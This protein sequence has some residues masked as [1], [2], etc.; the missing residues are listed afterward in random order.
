MPKNARPLD[1]IMIAT[2]DLMT[3]RD[4]LGQL[5]FTVAPDARHPFGTE[6]ACVFFA[7]STYLEP[8]SVASREDCEE[9]AKAGN[10]FTARDQAFRFRHGP[11]GMEAVVFKTED[12]DLDDASFRREGMSA[13][14]MLQFSRPMKMPDGSELVA[15]FKLAFAADLRSPDF[16]AFTCQR[17]NVP[18]TDRSSLTMHANGVTGI[19]EVVLSEN[20]P[21]DFG[22]FL[23]T[24][25]GLE[26]VEVSASHLEFQSP[27]AKINVLT[28]DLLEHFLGLKTCAHGRGLRGRA[29][30]FSVGSLDAVAKLLTGNGVEHRKIE[31]RIIVPEMP[32]QGVIFAFEEKA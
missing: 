6:N 25:T 26:P 5:G 29:I 31:N 11:E 21:S 14:Q 8:L 23:Q 17:I 1:H 15:S 12:A 30:I 3:A 19:C 32:G 22:G 24:V 13:G 27:N 4:R 20:N 9:S 16:F 2:A 28:T 7:D 10:V 18:A